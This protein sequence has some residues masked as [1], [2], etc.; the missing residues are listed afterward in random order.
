MRLARLNQIKV[1]ERPIE[2]AEIARATEV[3]LAGT[4]AEV[5]PV[6]RIGTLDFTPGAITQRMIQDYGT[7]VR[8]PAE[9][10]ATIVG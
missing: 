10:I 3:F 4:A 7:L 5:T 2:E 9:A 6:R 8:R 1:I